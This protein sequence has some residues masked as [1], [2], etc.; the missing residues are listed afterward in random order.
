MSTQ[1][2]IV[3]IDQLVEHVPREQ[4]RDGE[5]RVGDL[6]ALIEPLKWAD[7]D[8]PSVAFLAAGLVPLT[9]I[10]TPF[11]L[12]IGDL[13]RFA[14]GAWAGL[15][16]DAGFSSILHCATEALEREATI[17]PS[18]IPLLTGCGVALASAGLTGRPLVDLPLAELRDELTES[19]E[20]LSEAA[21]YPIRLLAPTPTADGRALDGIV[22][23]E[24]K[25]AGYRLFLAP[26]R[27]ARLDGPDPT[28]PLTYRTVLPGD[29]PDRLCDWLTGDV[30][31][32]GSAEV[33]RLVSGPR[34]LINRLG[35]LAERRREDE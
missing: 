24:A 20:R 25:R 23:R 1:L 18:D 30:F 3:H 12:S 8:T 33:E 21:G 10:E 35:A 6:R 19:R 22:R 26:G 7:A 2:P 28:D 15:L 14:L 4:R 13:R 16:G 27:I 32:R 34:R 11:L 31:A 5:F 29:D 17:S 9:S